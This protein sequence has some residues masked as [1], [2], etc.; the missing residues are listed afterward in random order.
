MPLYALGEKRPRIHPS[1]WIHPTAVLIGD[2]WVDA[3][4]S[5]WPNVVIR[6]DNSPIRIGARSSVQDGSVLH[7]TP[8]APTT[9]G[10]DCVIGHLV[11]LEGCTLEDLVLI[12]SNAVV[13]E[14]AVC[15]SGSLVGASSV[16]TIG[17][18]VPAGALAVGVPAKIK[19]DAVDPERIRLNV[20]AYLDHL[21]E[22][23]DGMRELDLDQCL[24]EDVFP[25]G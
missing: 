11:H 9:I 20:Q 5:I 19:P 3:E 8:W 14:E 22:H 7:T 4:A 23:R 15:R 25:A 21:R 18:E 10:A 2:V 1:A 13:L 16:V 24:A 17:R 12:G 6:A